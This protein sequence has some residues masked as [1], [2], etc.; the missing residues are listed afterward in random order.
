MRRN[1]ST[2]LTVLLASLL[3]SVYNGALADVRASPDLPS[4]MPVLFVDPVDV[5]VAPGDN[6]TISV[7][8]FN[9]TDSYYATNQTWNPGESLGP[10][11]SLYNYSLGNLYGLGIILS[12]DPTILDYTQ[13]SVA[14]PVETHPDGVL[15]ETTFLLKNEVN[16]TSGTYELSATSFLPA[17]SFNSPN[18]NSTVFNMTFNAIGLGICPLN[19]TLSSLAELPTGDF[20]IGIPHW[21]IRS[22]VTVIPEFPSVVILPLFITA[23]LLVVLFHRKRHLIKTV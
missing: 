1:A 7:K 4:D 23:T 14:I 3:I 6:L 21:V 22:D 13:R 5:I 17:S 2:L 15:H 18:S 12:W 19:I 16:E 20:P 8:I 10:P 11:G 9:L